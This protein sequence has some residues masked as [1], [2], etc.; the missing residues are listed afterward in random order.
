MQQELQATL[1]DTNNNSEIWR[2]LWSLQ[3]QIMEIQKSQARHQEEV[4]KKLG[5]ITDILS[6]AKGGWKVFIVVGTAIMMMVSGAAWLW[7]RFAK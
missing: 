1:P 3:E 2:R 5:E 4:S 6:Q 7:D